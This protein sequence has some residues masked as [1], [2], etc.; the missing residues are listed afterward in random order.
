MNSYF[1]EETGHRLCKKCAA[2]QRR[3]EDRERNSSA[4]AITAETLRSWQ[5]F[6]RLLCPL[7]R[8][9]INDLIARGLNEG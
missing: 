7:P 4:A 6:Q 3:D 9:M 5:E 1:P 2:S 8:I